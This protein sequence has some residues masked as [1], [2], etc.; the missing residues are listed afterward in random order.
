[1]IPS[2]D[3]PRVAELLTANPVLF[4]YA[5]I[6]REENTVLTTIL[7]F[8]SGIQGVEKKKKKVYSLI[9]GLATSYADPSVWSQAKGTAK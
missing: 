2:T 9:K 4:H 6:L 7:F 1:M 3:P 5:F 8:S